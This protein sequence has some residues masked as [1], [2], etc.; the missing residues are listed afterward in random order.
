MGT[1][2]T[3]LIQ[4]IGAFEV[5]MTALDGQESLIRYFDAALVDRLKHMI[6]ILRA[7]LNLLVVLRLN[8]KL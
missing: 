5:I 3:I 4:D 2:L 7:G 8:M 6:D 1:I